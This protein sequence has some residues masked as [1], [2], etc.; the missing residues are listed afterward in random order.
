MARVRS[1]LD[2]RA[3][4]SRPG[5]IVAP[6]TPAPMDTRLVPATAAHLRSMTAWFPDRR[7]LRA[8][9][10][11]AFRHPFTEATFLED[12]R[13]EDLT[14]RALL[15]ADGAVLAF[16]QVY[17]R[18]GRCHLGRLGVAPDRRGRGLGTALIR[19]LVAEGLEALETDECSLFVVPGNPAARLYAR[20]GFREAVYPG[21]GFEAYT[22]M[23]APGEAVLGGG[24]RGPAGAAP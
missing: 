19:G 15:G 1:G 11:P 3:G 18:L 6:P 2:A 17:D 12:A 20:L 8:W 10:G 9:G 16:G 5:R 24:P 22:F 7:S 4:A 21:P 13:F 14:S 23:T